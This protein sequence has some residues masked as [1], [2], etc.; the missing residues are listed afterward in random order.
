M[1]LPGS[2][3][4]QTLSMPC[5]MTLTQSYEEKRDLLI[6]QLYKR[7]NTSVVSRAYS[8]D[9]L[10]RP[11]T[12]STS[13]DGA[14]VND[15]FGYNSR[16]ELSTATVNNAAYSYD[17]DNIGNRETTQEA[18]ESATTYESNNLNQYTAIGDFEPTY[19]DAGNQTLVKTSTGIW[20]VVYDAENRP[21]LFTNAE[22][23][24]VVECTYDYMG[25]RAC[26]KV[27]INGTVTL[28]QRYIYRGYLQIACCDL[29]RANHPCL[30]L[31]T[32]DETQPK[33]SRPLSIQIDGTWYTYGLD[34]TKNVCELFTSSGYIASTNVY[35]PF[36]IITTTG[37]SKQT[38]YWNS[39]NYDREL[40][41]M[42]Y[43]KRYYN[44]LY[45]MWSR[46]DKSYAYGHNLY[47]FT[48]NDPIAY[49]DMIGNVKGNPNHG[50]LNL[51]VRHDLDKEE[52]E[53]EERKNANTNLNNYIN[54]YKDDKEN[55]QI[56][57]PR[58]WEHGCKT[59]TFLIELGDPIDNFIEA[60]VGHATVSVGQNFYDF[61]PVRRGVWEDGGYYWADPTFNLWEGKW[62]ANHR[63]TLNDVKQNIKKL[64]MDHAV[65][66]VITCVCKKHADSFEEKLKQLKNL[67][68]ELLWDQCATTVGNLF[69]DAIESPRLFFATS[70]EQLFKRLLD[71]GNI[72]C[73]PN[74]G[75]KPF[76]RILQ[77]FDTKY[78]WEYEP[79]KVE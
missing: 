5:N 51:Y 48:Q 79:I 60:K 37:S 39:E 38:L 16:S 41:L 30:W 9:P 49:F 53:D 40:G 75:K 8:Y 67:H 70:P 62:D 46:R 32:W 54:E 61:G 14:T 43:I 59:V 2:N 76:V 58:C 19:D 42:Y 69:F 1:D 11:V 29:T 56:T 23:A 77:E 25:R 13:K 34:L 71:T 63:V 65:V 27:T 45:S 17:Y 12:R 36:G 73:G 66:E 72:T 20:S 10:G 68:Y 44:P 3:L 21:V 55:T 35:S 52:K 50:G 33:A 74:K 47:N 7:S 24:T 78:K 31:I 6:R 22:S 15:S 57:N 26:K 4:L 28:H 64:A 18:A